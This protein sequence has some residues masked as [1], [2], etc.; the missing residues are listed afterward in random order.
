MQLI[1]RGASWVLSLPALVGGGCLAFAQSPERTA[2]LKFEVASIKRDPA[3]DSRRNRDERPILSPGRAQWNCMALDRVIQLAYVSFAN[4][5]R[6]SRQELEIRGGPGWIHS[7]QYDVVA[8]TEGK[9]GVAQ[10]SGPMLQL[11][12]EERFQLKIHRGTKEAA[13]YALTAARKGL[14]LAPAK[15]G[16]CVPRDLDHLSGG[17]R[18]GLAPGE[19]FCDEVSINSNKEGLTLEGHG[20]RMAEF[21]EGLNFDSLLD[22][23]VIDET[24]FSGSFDVQLKFWPMAFGDGGGK[25]GG[26]SSPRA[27]SPEP[28][29]PTIFDALEAQLGLKLSAAKGV[30]AFLVIDSVERPSEN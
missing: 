11:L 29:G 25:N 27:A 18:A 21:V 28:A 10:M 5:V 17:G 9:A 12:L 23:P 30:V 24:G 22:R 13:V 1:A 6:Y 4:G 26:R 15:E 7:D 19:F 14:R 16:G 20:M 2:T 8:T 3:C